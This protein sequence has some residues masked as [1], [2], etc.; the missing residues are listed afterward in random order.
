[1][2][3]PKQIAYFL[4]HPIQ[5]FS[6]LLREIA[7][8][9][10]LTVYY[11]SDVSVRGG[12]D[13]G[14]GQHVKWDTPLLDGY[15][16]IFLKNYVKTKA[17]SNSF[18]GVFNPGVLNALLKDKSPVVMVNG[19]TYSSTFMAVIFGRLLGRQI[20]LRAE[21]PLVNELRKSPRL[22][23]LKKI[24]LKHL[25][26][27]FFIDRFLYIGK[28][29][30]AFFEY[31]GV[32][33]QQLIFTPYS[34]DNAYFSSFW[35]QFKDDIPKVRADLGLPVDKK[36]ILFS[37]KYIPVKRPLDI[38]KAYKKLNNPDYALVFV[39]EGELRKEMESFIAVHQLD[40]VFLTGFVNQSVIPRYYAIC[41]V[42][43]VSSYSE[44]WGLAVNEAMNFEK[45]IIT[46]NTCGC[47]PDLVKEGTNGYTY[48]MGDTDALAENIN[49]VL[50]APTSFLV[51]AGL[52]SKKIVS[53]YSIEQSAENIVNSLNEI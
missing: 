45:P 12:M 3:T 39:G 25:F 19:W 5:Y 46:T 40:N 42:F 44:T 33:E 52:V 15:K 51:E 7:K 22:L 1:M 4:S 41:D 24:L 50:T 30:K 32:S 28:E 35:D 26:F 10:D 17:M 2:R 38:L 27:K 31:Y 53:Q 36:I 9:C 21:N 43:V 47:A 23:F 11:F 14:F 8:R 49:K 34:V 16:H 29:S 6:P 13:K 48:P 18:F 20:W 37:G